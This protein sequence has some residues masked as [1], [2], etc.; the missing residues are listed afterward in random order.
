MRRFVILVA[1]FFV[2]IPFGI[3]ISGCGK[4][5]VAAVFCS[6]GDTGPIVGQLQTITLQPKITGISLN[7]GEQGQIS[8]PSA[9]DC[10]GNSVSVSAYIYST[11]DMTIADVQPT[12]GRLCG[13]TWNRNTGG[14]IADYTTCNPTGKTGTANITA[15]ATGGA[16]GNSN[17]VPVYIHPIVT[18]LQL[19]NA[20]V[21]CANDPATNCSPAA[22]TATSNNLGCTLLSNGCCSTPI[23]NSAPAYNSNSC[24]SQTQT[25]QLAARVYAGTVS[26]AN[27]ISCVVGSL[28]YTAQSAGIVTIDQNGLATAQQPGSTNITSN[29]S[30][31]GASAGYFATCPPT[32]IT[33]GIPLANGQ[34]TTSIV[35]TQNNPQPLTT[36]VTDKNNVQLSGVTLEYV[37]TT[38]QTIA[39]STSSTI[40][41]TL[42]GTTTITAQCI[43]P[44]CNT[45]PFN[46]IGFLGNGQ[47][48]T[49]ND[50]ILTTP[51][52]NSTQL[53]IAS[54]QSQYI[55]PIDFTTPSLGAPIR[56]PFVPN[57]IALSDDGSTIYLGNAYELMTF[58]AITN[59]L[60][61]EFPGVPGTV[62]AVSPDNSTV[63]V[64]DSSRNLIYLASSTGSISSEIGGTAT[65]AE[66][67]PDSGTVYIT[68]TAGSQLLVHSN[69]TGWHT[70]PQ[71][72]AP[73]DVAITVPA[74]GAY[75]GG[76]STTAVSYCASVTGTSG[77][78]AISN[79][80]PLVDTVANVTD[81]V[82]AT[83]DGVH[84]LGATVT[85]GPALVDIQP[86][87][88]VPPSPTPVP[89]VP[90]QACQ[91]PVGPGYF[92]HTAVA[93]PLAGVTATAITGIPS[94][95]D[96]AFA[97]VTYTGTGKLP[98]YVP[99]T[100]AI[101]YITLQGAAIAPVAGVVSTDNNTFYLGT[102]GDNLVHILTRG[103]T[104]FVDTTTPIIPNLPSST[105]TTGPYATPN[106][107]VQ[108]PKK[109]TS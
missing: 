47:P 23:V 4:K 28:T 41:P 92:G 83:S 54:T 76:A 48:I 60:I 12:T 82:V 71:A 99:A 50:V 66:F 18:S 35:A 20:S 22:T 108:K 61:G 93:V 13:G 14:G 49:S 72:I 94:T 30:N 81:R 79:F 7:I 70:L 16:V 80:Y 96:S 90:T 43:P 58:S 69:F 40:T 38:P 27:N 97:F 10:K 36:I 68:D 73:T 75:L 67:S 8:A 46:S 89:N 9:T 63:V 42:P 52:T 11:T 5:T 98:Q 56:L 25:A 86:N 88:T 101:S 1:L 64:S 21:D 19:G 37:T 62:L 91:Q 103:A 107:I 24:V 53:F 39:A 2:T 106:L 78:T 105:G 102:S 104:G 29:L 95:S 109:S 57:S 32:T 31:A 55:I 45:A 44:S 100:G 26:A 85:N 84:I 33:L 15:A 3:S 77:T 65:H 6:G 74:V 87:H 34:T 51:G 59:G 17:P